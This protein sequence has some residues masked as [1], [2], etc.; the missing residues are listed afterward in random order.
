MLAKLGE[1]GYCRLDRE[2]E[3]WDTIWK[4]PDLCHLYVHCIMDAAYRE[5]VYEGMVLHPGQFVTSARKLAEES[6][7]PERAVKRYLKRLES[8]SLIGLKAVRN[9][10]KSGTIITVANSAFQADQETTNGLQMVYNTDNNQSANMPTNGTTNGTTNGHYLR[11]TTKEQE[12]EGD[13]EGEEDK[14]N[15]D[16]QGRQS[17]PRRI[18]PP[19]G[20]LPNPY[21]DSDINECIEYVVGE[22]EDIGFPC[23]EAQGGGGIRGYIASKLKGEPNPEILASISE[24]LVDLARRSMRD[25]VESH[26]GYIEK[27]LKNLGF[28]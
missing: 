2:I 16:E 21:P 22:L 8:M 18:D 1:R 24:M 23:D 15:M 4:N 6:G 20:T 14:D 7:I 10:S 27:A 11:T 9:G 17:S 25:D 5:K 19:D 3:K 12:K 26:I 13:R 28:Q